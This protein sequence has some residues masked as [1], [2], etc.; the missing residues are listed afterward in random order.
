MSEADDFEVF[1][2]TGATAAGDALSPLR[3]DEAE[4]T[5]F[6]EFLTRLDR[7]PETP[8]KTH[9]YA[10]SVRGR[11]VADSMAR[12]LAH[13]GESSSLLKEALKSPRHYLFARNQ[14]VK[15]RNTRHFDL[16]TFCHA[17]FLQ[18]HLFDKV[19]IRPKTN[20]STTKGLQALVRYYWDLLGIQQ[21]ADLSSLPFAKLRDKAD[22]L[23]TQAVSEGYTFIEQA[24]YDIIRAV[25]A[26][27]NTYG[28]GIIPRLIRY[29]KVETSLYGKDPSTG[30]KV[31][32]RPDGMLL[33]EN[34]GLN[35]ILSVKTTSAAS[36]DAFL[37]DCAKYRYELSEGMYLQIASEITG[38]HFSATVMLMIQTVLPFQ[39]ALLYWDA[40]DLQVGKY[41]YAQALDIIRRCRETDCWPGF[42]ALAEEG[43]HGIIPCKLPEYIKQEL[44][45]Q[46][47]P[48]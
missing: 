28:G 22:A 23:C 35:A 20:R 24:D 41:K 32:I 46:Y 48:Q 30:L 44:A 47:L 8:R 40:E 13:P 7:L 14:E 43:A 4:Y 2:L 12:Y 15:P 39:V 31:K 27:Y 29:A 33:E 5:P 37:R 45:P 1:D 16:G 11:V 21:D 3:F 38:R 9:N 25:R 34:F 18:P 6:E 26:A 10:L 17:A 19:Q 36:V 42:D